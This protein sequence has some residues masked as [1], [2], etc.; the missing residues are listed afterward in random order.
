MS[1]VIDVSDVIDVID[2]TVT[3]TDARPPFPILG[4]RARTEM[5]ILHPQGKRKISGMI[6]HRK[7]VKWVKWVNLGSW[8][9]IFETVKHC[10][11]GLV[12]FY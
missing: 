3:V 1:R 10:S 7:W 5:S 11:Y 8:A 6:G 2:V 12:S 4:I 9:H